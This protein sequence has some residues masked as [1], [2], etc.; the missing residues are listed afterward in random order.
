MDPSQLVSCADAAMYAAKKTK[1][2]QGR[3]EAIGIS[4]T[5]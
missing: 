4:A 5:A 1:R 2:L 3:A